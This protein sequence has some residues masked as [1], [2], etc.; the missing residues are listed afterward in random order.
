MKRKP[1]SESKLEQLDGKPVRCMAVGCGQM[2]FENASKPLILCDKCR[3]IL[4]DGRRKL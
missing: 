3:G 2:V 4:R 1:K